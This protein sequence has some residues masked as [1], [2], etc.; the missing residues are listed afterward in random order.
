[1]SPNLVSISI[2]S[3]TSLVFVSRSLTFFSNSAAFFAARSAASLAAEA[4]CVLLLLA[5]KNVS[6]GSQVR[7]DFP[8]ILPS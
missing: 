7:F 8:G 3:R 5:Y 1:M 4:S 6:V 2:G